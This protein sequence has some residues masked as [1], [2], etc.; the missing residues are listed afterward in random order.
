MGSMVAH[1]VVYVKYGSGFLEGDSS[2]FSKSASTNVE[3][4]NVEE[5]LI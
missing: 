4:G 5:C 3:L 2:S 1:A